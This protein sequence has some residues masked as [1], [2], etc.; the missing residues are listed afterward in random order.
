MVPAI[1]HPDSFVSAAHSGR[2]VVEGEWSDTFVADT[3]GWIHYNF[4]TTMS[5]S[6]G[7]P[8]R[9]CGPTSP[10]PPYAYACSRHHHVSVAAE[11]GDRWESF[12]LFDT[13]KCTPKASEAAEGR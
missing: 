10:E 4:S 5:V 1:T 13:S 6:T 7:F 12:F 9:D 11:Y 3:S 2:A 8:V